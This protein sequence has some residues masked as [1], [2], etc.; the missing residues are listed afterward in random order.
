MP[1][2]TQEEARRFKDSWRLVN[3]FTN[4]EARRQSVS[5]RMRDLEKLY[6]FAKEIGSNKQ[7]GEQENVWARWNRLREIA[8][9]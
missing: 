9:V 4:E 2:M 5:D 7:E 3:E 6:Q 1:M 8:G